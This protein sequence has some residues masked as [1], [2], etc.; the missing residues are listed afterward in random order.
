MGSSSSSSFPSELSDLLAKIFRSYL[1][2]EILRRLFLVTCG[3][4]TNAWT[5]VAPHVISTDPTNKIVGI[6]D[7]RS[8]VAVLAHRLAARILRFDCIGSI[9]EHM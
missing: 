2:A 4:D 5:G 9:A 7:I 6:I 1:V 3:A 8:E